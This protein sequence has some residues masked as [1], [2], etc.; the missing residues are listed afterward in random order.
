M[1]AYE[2]QVL[3]DIHAWRNPP[4]TWMG[5]AS[6][7]LRTGWSNVTDLVHHIPGVDWTMENIVAGL[8]DLVNEITQD[9]VWTEAVL[10]DFNGR[11]HAI[12]NLADIQ[13]MDLEHI[14]ETMS[15]LEK[16]YVG[17][18]TAEGA[19]T[20]LAGAAGIVPDVIAL[21]SI[22]LRAAGEM[23][24]YCGFDM[25]DPEER[26][27][28]LLI[29]DE[30]AKPGNS[31]KNV[32]LAPAMRTASKLARKQGTQLLE[33]IGVGNAIEGLLRRLGVSLTEKKLAQ[34]VPVTGAFVGGG[35][36]YMYTSSVCQTAYNL[37]RERFLV[38]KYGE[39][40]LHP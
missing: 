40:V 1:T 2:R 13:R 35:L 23:A 4:T 39:E 25:R 5:T 16:K 9:S 38:T 8:L 34:M 15:G 20:G 27:K 21:V 6:E 17:L 24:T 28:A 7:Q 26:M 14:D 12:M 30:V 36:N 22:N 10:K 31:K 18:A 3:A 37:Y 29:L 33:Q 32:T 11:G 19:A